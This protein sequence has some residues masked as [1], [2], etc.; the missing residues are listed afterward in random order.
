MS[1]GSARFGRSLYTEQHIV[2]SSQPRVTPMLCV[3]VQVG[4]HYE[5]SLCTTCLLTCA[6]GITWITVGVSSLWALWTRRQ[7][8]EGA[9]IAWWVAM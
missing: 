9:G 8:T 3:T 5:F 7:V 4:V 6:H 2:S 1:G